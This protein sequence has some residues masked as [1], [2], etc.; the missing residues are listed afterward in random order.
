M[1]VHEVEQ[2][3]QRITAIIKLMD[4]AMQDT[5]IKLQTVFS[6]HLTTLA[7]GHVEISVRAILSE[8]ARLR[9]NDQLKKFVYKTVSWE[10]SLNVEKLE[11]LLDRFD[12]DW[13][14]K[15]NAEISSEER[16]AVNSLKTLR[17]D[18][19]H[20]KQNGTGYI[21]V[22]RYFDQAVK[23]IKKLDKIVFS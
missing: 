16:E 17:D 11:K 14:K 9:S 13:V 20:G 5:D 8:Y 19:A 15:L 18:I 4:V 6:S 23:V 2:N 3:L 21:V 12:S 10:N 1:P 7:S 22:K